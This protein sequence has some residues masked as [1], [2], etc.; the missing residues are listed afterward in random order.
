[1]Q[2]PACPEGAQPGPGRWYGAPLEVLGAG[3]GVLDGYW[4]LCAGYRV[5]CAGCWVPCPGCWLG[6]GCLV[7][8][9]QQEP[10]GTAGSQWLLTFG[11]SRERCPGLT[12]AASQR[13]RLTPLAL[14]PHPGTPGTTSPSLPPSQSC[15]PHQQTPPYTA[16]RVLWC[17]PLLRCQYPTV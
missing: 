9:Q 15:A 7:R 17:P 2:F 6:A 10:K 13:S 16:Q 3:A 4:V 1:M 11:G 5:L 8:S 12:W 14:D